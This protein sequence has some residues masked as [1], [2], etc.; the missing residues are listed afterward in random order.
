MLPY[1][2]EQIYWSWTT[3]SS[4]WNL[5]VFLDGLHCIRFFS[6]KATGALTTWLYF[7]FLQLLLQLL[8]LFQNVNQ[9]NFAV[10]NSVELLF[11]Q[12]VT[13][14]MKRTGT[15]KGKVIYKKHLQIS[16]IQTLPFA[17][18]WLL[19]KKKTKRLMTHFVVN[20][21]S[22]LFFQCWN[23]PLPQKVLFFFL[24]KFLW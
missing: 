6:C 10:F 4:K 21:H 15:C 7:F 11:R 18:V 23:L 8:H 19:K 16:L 24:A 1:V 5:K 17:C 2:P 12:V 9:G 20:I 22:P 13:I 14:K 3:W